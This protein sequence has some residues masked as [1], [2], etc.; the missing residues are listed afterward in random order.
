MRAFSEWTPRLASLLLPLRLPRRRCGPRRSNS[1]LAADGESGELA[2]CQGEKRV[3]APPPPSGAPT[4]GAGLAWAVSEAEAGPS[5]GVEVEGARCG[6]C[7]SH[8]PTARLPCGWGGVSSC[9]VQYPVLVVCNY[10][11]KSPRFD[12]R[13]GGP[14]CAVHSGS[15]WLPVTIERLRC[16]ECY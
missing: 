8:F 6:L 2:K 4:S 9:G 16:G 12:F 14:I 11:S 5:G 13:L 10:F 3:T 7:R 1:G 15:L